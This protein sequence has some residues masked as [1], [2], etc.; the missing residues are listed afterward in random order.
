MIMIS[1]NATPKKLW[2]DE[3]SVQLQEAGV[4]GISFYK[5][6]AAQTQSVWMLEHHKREGISQTNI[7]HFW[8]FTY[9]LAIHM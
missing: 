7:K 3:S 2:E 6:S 1:E 9:H 8:H 5:W 4:A